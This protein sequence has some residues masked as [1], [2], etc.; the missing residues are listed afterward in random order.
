M[1]TVTYAWLKVGGE[2]HWDEKLQ[3][4]ILAAFFYG[5]VTTQ[6]PGG[7]LAHK[8]GG[9]RL[10]LFG[11]FW[12]AALTI[13]TPI[14]TRVGDYPAIICVRILEGIGEVLARAALLLNIYIIIT[15]V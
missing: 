7:L 1:L 8:F 15:A 3:G 9:K 11:I 6:I 12:T 5:Y 4:I 10:L 13:L 14:L 2:F